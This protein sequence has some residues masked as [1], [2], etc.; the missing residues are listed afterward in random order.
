MRRAVRLA[1]LFGVGLLSCSDDTTGSALPEP[2]HVR[3]LALGDSYTAG[4]SVPKGKSW[5]SQLA[6]SLIAD[7]VIVTQLTVIARTG[8]TTTDLLDTLAAGTTPPHDFVTLQIGVNNQFGGLPLD[9]F[10]NE[11]AQ[12]LDRAVALAGD[13]PQR[14][15]AL[16]I[17]DY[18]VTPVGSRIDPDRVRAEIDSYNGLITTV[19]GD[20]SVAT[21]DV[22]DISRLA[23]GDPTLVARDGLHPSAKMYA[24]WVK[25]LQPVVVEALT[26]RT[27]FWPTE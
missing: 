20:R 4:Q 23:L 18:S 17:P 15:L 26:R 2:V 8:W 9:L 1:A 3:V 25:V 21:I 24:Q 16:S 22:T 12:L 10:E 6:D 11:F 19:A 27:V 5:P 14:V 13:D 7:R